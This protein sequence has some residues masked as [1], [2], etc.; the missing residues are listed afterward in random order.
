MEAIVL[1]RMLKVIGRS[2]IYL[3]EAFISPNNVRKPKKYLQNMCS[4]RFPHHK[5]PII[6]KIW[7]EIK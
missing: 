4:S 2:K 7:I 6:Y 1:K 3:K 5:I